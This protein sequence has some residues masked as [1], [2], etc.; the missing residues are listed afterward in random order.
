LKPDRRIRPDTVEVAP[1]ECLTELSTAM[2]RN[3]LS[4]QYLDLIQFRLLRSIASRAQSRGE[5]FPNV[6]E[7][8]RF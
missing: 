3:S 6:D 2:V 5:T 8:T 4:H 1:T 7:W